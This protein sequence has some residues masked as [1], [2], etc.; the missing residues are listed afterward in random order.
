MNTE[1]PPRNTL[2]SLLRQLD[3]F[4]Y[5][6]LKITDLH[7]LRGTLGGVVYDQTG[8]I[9]PD[10]QEE[11]GAWENVAE[12][13]LAAMLVTDVLGEALEL[14]GDERK[15][16][17]LAAWL[18][19]SGKKTER[20]W[21]RTIEGWSQEPEKPDQTTAEE[22]Q[23][24]ASEILRQNRLLEEESAAQ[25]IIGLET[26][27]LPSQEPQP[28]KPV[29]R[30]EAKKKALKAQEKM[31]EAENSIDA[32]FSPKVSKIM[33][34]T[35]PP[36]KEGH[37][38]NLAEKIMWFADACLTGTEI[39][40]IRQRFDDLENDPKNG[41]RNRKFSDSFKDRYEGKN[42]YDLQRELGNRYLK[43]F[44]Q[45]IGIEPEKFYSWL[46][47]KVDER[48]ASEQLPLM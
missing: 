40:P 27:N 11:G 45:R 4:E 44:S 26:L 3:Q 12:H 32:G 23:P 28:P 13:C 20:M 18:H 21:Q 19:D 5:H 29:N 46:Q 8:E 25:K 10:G 42:L 7:K 17:N 33:K 43:E 15:D 48:L 39:K 31:E 47:G 38:N 1:T 9:Y 35:I 14:S 34:A 30:L 24:S 41:P 6:G 22:P 16:L 37:G 2:Q 36:L